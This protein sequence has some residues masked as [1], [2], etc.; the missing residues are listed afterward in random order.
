MEQPVGPK[1]ALRTHLPGDAQPNLLAQIPGNPIA[2]HHSNAALVIYIDR[3]DRYFSFR[4]FHRKML[5]LNSGEQ[6]VN[7]RQKVRFARELL[8]GCIDNRRTLYHI[9]RSAHKA[10]T[11]AGSQKQLFYH[12]PGHAQ[13]ALILQGKGMRALRLYIQDSERDAIVAGNR[14][15]DGGMHFLARRRLLLHL[16][17]RAL[18]DALRRARYHFQVE[19]MSHLLPGQGCRHQDNLPALEGPQDQAIGLSN[20]LRINGRQANL[21]R[22]KA[23]L[24]AYYQ[25]L[26]LNGQ[27]RIAREQKGAEFP[28]ALP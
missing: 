12:P 19:G 28:A 14:D 5:A 2:I 1:S 13:D 17:R 22:R 8:K 16:P 23:G 20:L 3:D 26:L 15:G 4:R 7:L 24:R 9:P 27:T 6:G 25:A 18:R 21:K 11:R 10:G